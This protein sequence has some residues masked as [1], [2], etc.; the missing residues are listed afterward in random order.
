MT[1]LVPHTPHQQCARC[2]SCESNVVRR[3]GFLRQRDLCPPCLIIEAAA[4]TLRATKVA[5]A[6]AI[7]AAAAVLIALVAYRWPPNPAPVVLGSISP[8]PRSQ[9]GKTSERTV[10][11]LPPPIPTASPEQGHGDVHDGSL[12]TSSTNHISSEETIP[13][14]PDVGAEVLPP[15]L[16]PPELSTATNIA[17]ATGST[18]PENPPV[19]IIVEVTP[20]AVRSR[21]EPTRELV[22]PHLS[23]GF[24]AQLS[25]RCVVLSVQVDELGSATATISERGGVN[26]F[27]V[28]AAVRDVAQPWIP[29]VN[30]LGEKMEDTRVVKYCWP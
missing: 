9:E 15:S 2:D 3:V 29:A 26:E 24:R 23:E 27:F 5:T 20:A 11:A 12:T 25:G 7:F 4:S 22:L 1:S 17:P 6:A 16:L 8:S 13:A 10:L 14:Q 28:S 18:L 21:A 19:T 30:A